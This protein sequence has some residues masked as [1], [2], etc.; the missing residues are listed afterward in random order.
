MS[1]I[2][3]GLLEK[4]EETP[5]KKKKWLNELISLQLPKVKRKG[6]PWAVIP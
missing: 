5:L 3:L 1:A 4:Q 2:T 6:A